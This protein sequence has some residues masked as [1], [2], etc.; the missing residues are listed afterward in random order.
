[1][2]NNTLSIAAYTRISVD[3][4]IDSLNTSI[5]NQKQII[6]DYVAKFFPGAKVDFYEDKDRSGYT[7][8]QRLGYQQMKA[9]MLTGCYDTMI[10]K[11]FSRF[12]R[13]NSHGLSE[14]EIFRDAGIRIIAIG[15]SVDYPVYTKDWMMIQFIFL[16]NET[17]VTDTSRKVRIVIENKQEKGEWICN[18]P[19]GYYL[20]PTK[21]NEILID[22]EGAN[23]VRLIFDLYNS[24]YGYK[25]I[26][27]YLTKH[28][29]PT[30]KALI[31]KHMDEK[32]RDSSHIDVGDV[33]NISTV[34]GIIKNDY[35]IGT[36]RQRQY[37][38]PGIN[39][40]DK[41][42]PTDKHIIF[43]NHHEPIIDKEIFKKAQERLLGNKS[44]HYKGERKY[45]N[46]YT[47]IIYCADC[48]S[49]MFSTSN[50][51]R[52]DGYVCGSYHRRGLDGC[53]SHHIHR[54]RI[55]EE[56]KSF[57]R[58]VRDSLQNEISDYS[59]AG[60]AR[61]AEQNKEKITRLEKEIEECK[62]KLL[63]IAKTKLEEN[64]KNPENND[65]IEET[66]KSL[67]AEYQD[68]LKL[69]QSQVLFLREDS[70]KRRELK[71]NINEILATFD[72]ILKKKEFTR[73]D[74]SLIIDKITVNS[75][76][77]VTLYLKNS[78]REIESIVK[79]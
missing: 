34:A 17:P 8:E 39:K 62:G 61:K 3:E 25:K 23:V 14:L 72:R 73:E 51:K 4:E 36:L 74:I 1:M 22:E 38:R 27:K 45:K 47:G 40:A 35:Y 41:K 19:Y 2:K 26:A 18:A 42:L 56:V 59:I 79:G 43:E 54:K 65:I 10:V 57:I 31:K 58:E 15:D 33:W 52:P 64:F 75:D 11:D 12:A 55:D 76:K 77:I 21:K 13:R 70:E 68:K 29:Y 28:K 30:G 48:G 46:P 9:K 69:L 53:T 50:P 60:S 6:N 63:Y 37:S 66:Y 16:R 71:K 20:H 78:I 24:G 44:V 5:E 32:D 49:P 67:E 7:F